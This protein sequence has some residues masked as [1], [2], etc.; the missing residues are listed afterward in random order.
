M[1]RYC[2]HN[3]AYL[4]SG[5]AHGIYCEPVIRAGKCIVGRGKQ[6]VCFEDGAECIV[7]RRCLRLREKCKVH[8]GSK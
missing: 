8:G 6:L 4:R 2:Y 3:L 5:A 7:V 1:T